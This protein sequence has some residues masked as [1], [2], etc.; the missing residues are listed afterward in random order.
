VGRQALIFGRK[1]GNL[2]RYQP[3]TRPSR[4]G[5]AALFVR[6][7]KFLRMSRRNFIFRVIIIA[8]L[9]AQAQVWGQATLK[10]YG[11]VFS[12]EGPS[13]GIAVVLDNTPYY[14]QTDISGYYYFYDIPS[15][16]YTLHC[17]KNDIRYS[18]AEKLV[19]ADG[20]PVQRDI[21]LDY[22]TINVAPVVVEASPDLDQNNRAMI[23]VDLTRAPSDMAEVIDKIP[24]LNIIAA[25]D[26]GET[27]VSGNGARPEAIEI[28]VDGRRINSILTGKADLGQIPIG[29]I[30]RVEYYPS[31]TTSGKGGLA[32]TLNFISGR[33]ADDK[34]LVFDLYNGS[35]GRKEY[36]A[37][38]DHA[39][40]GYGNFEIGWENGH[41]DNDYRYKDYFG[42]TQTRQNAKQN[43][44]KYFISYANSIKGLLLKFSGYGFDGS[45]GV[46]GKTITPSLNAHSEKQTL[47]LG[48][49]ADYYLKR[50]GTFGFNYSWQK[51]KTQYRDMIGSIPYSTEYDENENVIGLSGKINSPKNMRTEFH[52]SLTGENLSGKD[53]LRPEYALGSIRREIYHLGGTVRYDKP[54][55]AL[56]FGIGLSGNLD[57]ENSQSHSAYGAQSSIVYQRG[58]RFGLNMSYAESYRLPGLAE[59]NWKE[60]VFVVANPELKPERSKQNSAEMFAEYKAM[61]QWR[62]SVEYKDMRYKN[63]IY[64]RRSQGLRYKPVNISKSDYFGTTITAAYY[65][66]GNIATIEFSRVKSVS[67]NREKGQPYFGKYVI[68]Q[69]L[70]VNRLQVGLNYSTFSGRFEINDVSQRY[71]LEENTKALAPYSLINCGFGYKATIWHLETDLQVRIENVT[72]ENYE[73]L[74]YQPMPTRTYGIGINIKI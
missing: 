50:F 1:S 60:D 44:D 61:G 64:W 31:G 8:G 16:T 3:K 35:F 20:L 21:Y 6:L 63:L 37:Q 43:S 73:L 74:E 9:L 28:F 24:G 58:I 70:Y 32:G 5:Q 12:S 46:P 66:P 40:A 53:D 15:G 67:L 29:A 38:Y 51:R 47:S 57:R 10:L 18:L 71:Y 23:V 36:S 56:N 25:A 27:F 22:E 26:G 48:G 17:R 54:L 13:A 19:V 72:N 55:S 33:K 59:L 11:Q 52:L 69:P 41:R 14:S 7:Q 2:P 65:S 42:K 62:Y 30:R 45:N 68:F 34:S 39:T 49:G 4:E